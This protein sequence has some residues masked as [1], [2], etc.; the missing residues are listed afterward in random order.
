MSSP[1]NPAA[2]QVR[3]NSTR[4]GPTVGAA[5]YSNLSIPWYAKQQIETRGE[6]NARVRANSSLPNK[7]WEAISDQII[8]YKDKSKTLISDLRGMGLVDK[9]AMLQDESITWERADERGDATIAMSL[10][11][12]DDETSGSLGPQGTA[13]P[14]VFDSYS[15]GIRER[16][17]TGPGQNIDIDNWKQDSATENVE[18]GWESLVLNGWPASFQFDALPSVYGLTNHPDANTAQLSDWSTGGAGGSN[19]GVVRGDFRTAVQMLKDDMFRPRGTPYWAYI[20]T[21][22]E[23]HM[24]DAEQEGDG[25]RL[26]QDRVEDLS[27]IDRVRVSEY[28]P[29]ESLLVF[30]PTAD[31]IDL[32]IPEEIQPV[33]WSNGPDTRDN[34]MIWSCFAPRVKS[35]KAKQSGIAYLS[36]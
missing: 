21:D 15:I 29:G 7:V 26:V 23:D 6:Q 14:C 27:S 33:Q 31:V 9:S 11:T 35:T 18:A 12:R 25:S 5:T 1:E 20:S 34:W 30:R 3:Q 17:G 19:P 36:R 22:L 16:P 32:E 2:Q 24:N 13:L 4:T 8:E 10:E 28:L